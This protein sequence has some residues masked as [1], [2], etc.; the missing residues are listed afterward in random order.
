MDPS[1]K[2]ALE[3]AREAA[4]DG[5]VPIGAVIV[6]NGSIVGE[7][8]N[9]K[10]SEANA[11]LHAE[12]IAIEQASKIIGDW[13]LNECELWVTLE[14]C[15]MCMAALYQARIGR[16]YFGAW[17]AKAGALS[18]GYKFNE[19]ARLNHRFEATHVPSPECEVVLKEF[20]KKL[21]SG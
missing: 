5:E 14:P 16:V 8:R 20:F 19:D 3:L 13:R 1:L 12:M 6:Q 9:R 7:G 10:E 4:D 11:L 17:D 21:R 2:R 15:L 18:L